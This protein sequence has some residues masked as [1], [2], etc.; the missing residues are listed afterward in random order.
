MS[1]RQE[2]PLPIVGVVHLDVFCCHSAHTALLLLLLL[3]TNLLLSVTLE[4]INITLLIPC[5]DWREEKETRK[6]V[7]EHHTD[8]TLKRKKKKVMV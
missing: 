1:R 4:H 8:R 6:V 3:K 5:E 2:G 7:P